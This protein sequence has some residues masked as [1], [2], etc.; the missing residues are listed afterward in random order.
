MNPLPLIAAM[1]PHQWVKNVFV[2]AALIFA[3]GEQGASLLEG[4]AVMRV[5]FAVAAF[6]FCASAIYLV[7]D[8]FDVES[9][10]KHPEKCKRPI[11][12]GIL[13]VAV[14]RVAAVV[15]VLGGLF[16]AWPAD[17]DGLGVLGCIVAYLLINS[18][19]SWRLK[20]VVLLDVF[21]IAAGFL[22]RVMAG[23]FAV[24]TGVSHWLL[25]CT[26][27]LSLF[28]ALC[29]RQA[30]IDLLGEE[31]GEHRRILLEYTPEF[32]SQ[33]TAALAACAILSYAMYTVAEETEAKFGEE[34]GLWWSVPFVVFGLFRYMLL[35]KTQ[36]GGGSPTKVL[37][38]G[39]LVFAAN[40]VLWLGT[41]IWCLSMA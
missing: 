17:I 41:V 23:G 15:C 7:N 22:L 34:H 35:V 20:H 13:P 14:A 36:R 21:C 30:E 33:A 2:L 24:G 26:M 6:C 31:R 19:Y 29:K 5:V 12:A 16:L 39:D 28:L 18:L 25:L 40:A 10:R 27:F 38:G 32:L 37:L 11:A 8:I 3:W 1:R 4:P 9:D